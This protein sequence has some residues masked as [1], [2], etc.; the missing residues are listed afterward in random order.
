V[1][2]FVIAA[3]HAI[4]LF[5][6]SMSPRVPAPETASQAAMIMLLLESHETPPRVERDD[7]HTKTPPPR[8]AARTRLVQPAPLGL[9]DTESRNETAPGA[10]DWGREA[11]ISAAHG[12]Q[13]EQEARRRASA[14]ARARGGSGIS[15]APNP[16]RTHEFG[17]SR[18]HTHRIEPIEDGGTFIWI[19]DRCG[20]VLK[21]LV[22]PV[23]RLGKIAA[24]GDLFEHMRDPPELGTEPRAGRE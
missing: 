21:G 24:R 10:I 1:P 17:W 7:A 4:L 5:M 12:L 13:A 14:F 6:L 18:A 8:P 22:I 15:L 11:E 9:P 19:N 23:C 2:L 20:V 16:Y 3:A